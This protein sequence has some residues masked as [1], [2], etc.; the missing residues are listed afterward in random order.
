MN[1]PRCTTTG[2]IPMMTRQGVEI[3]YCPDCRG[4]WLDKGEIYYFTKQP[5]DIYRELKEAAKHGRPGNRACPRTGHK[6]NEIKVL[7][8]EV[9]LDYS[10]YSGGIWF[11]D[12]ELE[13]LLAHY[14]D[15]FSLQIDRTA[16]AYAVP[17]AVA[18]GAAFSDEPLDLSSDIGAQLDA[19]GN[20]QTGGVAASAGASI[21]SAPPLRRLPR[22]AL[23]VLPSLAVRSVSVLF[24]LYALLTVVLITATLFTPLTPEVALITSVIIAA[25]QF[26]LG[27][28]IMDLTLRWFYKVR[29]VSCEQLP[30]HLKSFIYSTCMKHK[31]KHPRMGIIMDGSPNAFT[32]GHTP[33]NARI[34]ITRGL[35][36]LLSE[37]EVKS[38]VAHE[39]GHALHWD[40][41]V[42]TMAH[43]VPMILYYIYR[44]LIR[45]RSRGK[46][47]SAPIRIGIA[48][49]AYIL[50][51]VSEYI[52][53]W[54]SR[55]REYYADRFA[56]NETGNPNA[57]ASG[58]VKIG[59]GLA[60]KDS[61]KQKKEKSG[62]RQR[63]L[64][65]VGALGIFDSKAGVSMVASSIS[66]VSAARSMGGEVD[67]E[68]LK[69]AMKWDMW[70]PWAMYYELHSTHPLI[71]KRIT[72]IST[73]AEVM[74][75]EPYIRF[76]LRQPE[77]YWDE[78]FVDLLIK[79]LPLLSFLIISGAYGFTRDPQLIGVALIATGLAS[80][81]K[82]KF[83]YQ[84]DFFPPMAVS[85]L[86][87]KVK[88]SGVRPVPCKLQ[89]TII[90]RGI[91][92]LIW[93]EDFVMQDETGIIFMDYHQP[94]PLW[95]FFFGLLKGKA[96]ANQ[97]AEVTGWFRRAP[98]PYLELKSITVAGEGTRSCYTYFMK[99]LLSFL[100]IAVGV[101]LLFFPLVI[102]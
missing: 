85:S 74:G 54:L 80:F 44:T 21:S 61:Q 78:F 62:G 98:I 23:P 92:G 12:S 65:A 95:N 66:S 31:M 30:G 57:L 45:M 4:I 67:K 88:V 35:M 60:G 10:P 19:P 38:V 99:Y 72:H 91:P 49:G 52:V 83:V 75:Q 51:I 27:P 69:N 77:S 100:L 63:G 93:S 47:N 16:S 48:I 18:P 70:N 55:T 9:A 33:N 68:T 1:C 11:D 94:I 32:Y 34:V 64:S 81:V 42:M 56:G 29:W 96:Y 5:A 89:G 76:N 24:L 79:F 73:Q 28:Y 102:V 90:G 36:D 13:T 3:D 86:L 8:G 26:L 25:F 101:Y 53:L 84:A 50:Y 7:N 14:G 40:M 15:T 59:Y 37:E 2:M 22:G 43:L 20:S 46:D 58:L 82:T 6:M 39:I 41:L 97:P 71:A 17:G 87:K